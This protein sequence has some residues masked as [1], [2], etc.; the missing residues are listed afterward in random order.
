[1]NLT[2]PTETARQAQPRKVGPGG[3]RIARRRALSRAGIGHSPYG[4][5]GLLPL[6]EMRQVA[7]SIG[8]DAPA[9]HPF[10]PLAT[11]LGALRQRDFVVT[12]QSG[13]APDLGVYKHRGN[14]RA[15][16]N[17]WLSQRPKSP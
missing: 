4:D 12:R 7:P 10:G 14:R 3:D 6:K 15:T 9:A 16:S 13:A 8:R 5:R 11:R 1:M 17:P 2:N